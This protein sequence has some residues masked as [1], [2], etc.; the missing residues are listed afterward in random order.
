MLFHDISWFICQSD[1][2]FANGT[3]FGHGLVEGKFYRWK[4]HDLHGKIYGFRLRFSLKPIH[5]V[6]PLNSSVVFHGIRSCTRL[7]WLGDSGDGG[8][9][10]A[11]DGSV[12]LISH[13]FWR[14]L[15]RCQTACWSVYMREWPWCL[16]H[17]KDPLHHQ[18]PWFFPD[19]PYHLMVIGGMN[20]HDIPLNPSYSPWTAT[21]GL[22][23]RFHIFPGSAP[24]RCTT[25]RLTTWPRVRHTFPGDTGAIRGW[26]DRRCCRSLGDMSFKAVWWCLMHQKKLHRVTDHQ[27]SI[28]Q[29]FTSTIFHSD[30]INPLVMKL[31][32]R[33]STKII[34]AAGQVAEGREEQVQDDC[35]FAGSDPES[36]IVVFRFCLFFWWKC[37]G[38]SAQK[39]FFGIV[40]SY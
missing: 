23:P 12:D 9:T 24:M 26:V 17:P 2:V 32:T 36:W 7:W 19:V 18:F 29:T 39:R 33:F 4:P 14:Y 5:R 37:W 16:E 25:L 10:E 34:T 11:K 8:S 13:G 35:W 15:K 1:S 20:G 21:G 3:L 22:R 30:S 38:A 31:V 40:E 28:S 27:S 6:W